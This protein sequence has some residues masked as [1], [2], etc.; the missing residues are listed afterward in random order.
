MK[1]AFP[2]GRALLVALVI[3]ATSAALKWATPEY[4]SP[5]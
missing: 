5:E 2:L 4:L 1:N 3:V